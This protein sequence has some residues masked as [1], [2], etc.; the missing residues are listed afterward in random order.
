MA[1]PKP[2]LILTNPTE[3]ERRRCWKATHPLW[4]AALSLDGYLA[5]EQRQL[6]IPLARNGG[7]A[8][9]ILTTREGESVPSPAGGS[10]DTGR[11]PVLSSCE[12]LK[13]RALVRG[14]DGIIREGIAHG[15]ASVFTDPAYRGR[16]YATIMMRQLADTLGKMEENRGDAMFSVLYSDIGKKFYAANE[17]FPHPSSHA[18]FAASADDTPIVSPEA[19]KILHFDDLPPLV[20][21]DEQLIRK[22]IAQPSHPGNPAIRAAILPDLDQI[23]WHLAR[24]G[25]VCEQLF[26]RRPS[27][28]GALYTSS[29]GARVWAIWARSFSGTVAEPAKNT[30]FFLR[31]VVEEGVSDEDLRE[32]LRA[33][34]AVAK[35]EAADSAC[36]KVQMW[37]SDQRVRAA[38]EEL[39]AKYVVRDNDSIT[40]LNALGEIR[41][42]PVDWVAN[43]KYAWC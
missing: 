25:F 30:L 33:I 2:S 36:A 18:D 39:G 32:A 34:V 38:A 21:A 15:V 19:L 10:T 35:K 17:W 4:G 28:H 40:S 16:G 41:G 1:S 14:K 37:N 23:H 22:E 8:N 13:K 5:R 7:L 31:F 42:E 11:R 20:A 12:T 24:E 3:E 29:S 9:W 27:I 6:D 43:E 26:S